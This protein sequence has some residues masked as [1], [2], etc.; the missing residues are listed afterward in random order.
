MPP[1]EQEAVEQ[2]AL[3]SRPWSA[4]EQ[5]KAKVEIAHMEIDPSPSIERLRDRRMVLFFA[6]LCL[7]V[8][9][10]YTFLSY[11]DFS[12]MYYADP[13][14]WATLL[15]GRGPAPAQYRLGVLWPA[16]AMARLS[17]N[18]LPV[19]W[20]LGLL[21]G[22]FLL[23]ALPTLLFFTTRTASFLRAGRMRKWGILLL[24]VFLF[25]FYL[26][27]TLW[28]HK[29]ETMANFACL[30]VSLLLVTRR[31][32]LPRFLAVA[33]LVAIAAYAATVR[34]DAAFAFHFGMLLAC[35]LPGSEDLP[36]GRA[37]QG[38]VSAVSLLVVLGVEHFIKTVLFPQAVFRDP[39]FQLIHNL[40]SPQSLFCTAIALA[41]FYA[42]LLVGRRHWR[43]LATWERGLLIGSVVNFG[44]Y[45][46]VGV[47]QEV[48]I[49]LPFA[50]TVLAIS[51]PRL[52]E[53]LAPNA[54]AT[55]D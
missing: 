40:R 29:P 39:I 11:W 27:W 32:R 48:R 16:G 34:A 21:D 3:G 19:R 50:M 47:S 10:S 45:F 28:F 51:A 17:H 30:V 35:L 38:G 22:F 25:Q 33:A 5:S 31:P 6:C 26:A 46:V 49:F 41:P 44:L 54:I 2:P 9:G 1:P 52:L 14:E 12:K 15:A 43:E 23:I 36:L 8:V 42:T 55:G 13:R 4:V 20:G 18:H 7:M 53:Y 24:T 37:L